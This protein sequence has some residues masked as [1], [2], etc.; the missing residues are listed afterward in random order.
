MFHSQLE[1]RYF[2]AKSRYWTFVGYPESLKEGY[3]SILNDTGLEFCISPLHDRDINE[4]SFFHQ[5]P[6]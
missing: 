1:K 5:Y 4:V 3:I 2:M 6:H